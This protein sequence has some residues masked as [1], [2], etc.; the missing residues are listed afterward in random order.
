MIEQTMSEEFQTNRPR[1]AWATIRGYYY[2]FEQTVLSWLNLE[3]RHALELERGEDVDV[4]VKSVVNNQTIEDRQLRQIKY[5][6]E[7][8]TLKSP[9]VVA[10]FANFVEHRRS[11]ETVNLLFT[12]LTNAEVGLERP[13]ILS[14]GDRG[15][16]GWEKVRRGELAD[17][18]KQNYVSAFQILLQGRS[19]PDGLNAATWTTFTDFINSTSNSEFETFVA[20]FQFCTR[21]LTVEELEQT[22]KDLLIVKGHANDINAATIQYQSLLAYIIRKLS[23][24]NS[25]RLTREELF[26]ALAVTTLAESDRQ[27]LQHL[28][29]LEDRL[30][31]IEAEITTIKENLTANNRRDDQQD[32]RLDSLETLAQ[33]TAPAERIVG[34]WNPVD[35]ERFTDRDLEREELKNLLK[36]SKHRVIQVGGPSGVG[37]T[38]LV[39]KVLHELHEDSSLSFVYIEVPDGEQTDFGNDRARFILEALAQTLEPEQRRTWRFQNRSNPTT[40]A[41][42]RN[43]LNYLNRR[44]ILYLDNAE[45][46]LVRSEQINDTTVNVPRDMAELLYPMIV[47]KNS[48]MTVILTSQQSVT[49]TSDVYA[50]SA[51]YLTEYPDP[52][53]LPGLPDTDALQLLYKL[54]DDEPVGVREVDGSVLQGIIEQSDKRPRTLEALVSRVRQ[55][56]KAFKFQHLLDDVKTLRGIFDDPIQAIYGDDVLSPHEARVLNTLA[57]TSQ[58]SSGFG[59]R[60]TISLMEIAQILGIDPSSLRHDFRNLHKRYAVQYV[61]DDTYTLRPVDRTYLLSRLEETEKRALHKQA[62]G[63]Y[64]THQKP[65]EEIKAFIDLDCWLKTIEH[66]VQAEEFDDA[67]ELLDEIDQKFL[68]PFGYAKLMLDFNLRVEG[69]LKEPQHVRW[70]LTSLGIALTELGEYSWAHHYLTRALDI[71]KSERQQVKNLDTYENVG[72]AHGHLATLYLRTLRLADM[73]KH[74]RPA[75]K[76]AFEIYRKMGNGPGMRYIKNLAAHFGNFGLLEL[77]DGDPNKAVRAMEQALSLSEKAKHPEGIVRWKG[78]LG[79]A[80]V[81]ATRFVDELGRSQLREAL[82]GAIDAELRPQEAYSLFQLGITYIK[83]NK[84]HFAATCFIVAYDLFTQIDSSGEALLNTGLNLSLIKGK[85]GDFPRLLI[86]LYENGDEILRAATGQDYSYFSKPMSERVRELMNAINK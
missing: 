8:V 2:Q 7:N 41:Q 12:Y 14:N 62:A 78:E 3:E 26:E 23:H 30:A 18:V 45:S 50:K 69:K 42:V 13:P 31:H 47:E 27:L 29:T 58:V 66:L 43:L 82:Q 56:G 15:I 77:L 24:Q 53:G 79:M 75:L 49:F 33:D 34:A 71:A 40:R 10:A 22:I 81:E 70:N 48:L 32:R 4:V 57:I 11:N 60:K 84:L 72:A 85:V 17:D 51:R 55:W 35:L 86:E 63:Y 52:N 6:Q 44:T 54:D 1:D 5:H 67:Y 9:G 39:T 83:D 36:D 74:L 61:E 28:D 59:S 20:Q 19:K 21:Q 80:K 64:Q 16:D 76:T 25:K 73:R 65:L 37:K 46:W 38:A 68:R